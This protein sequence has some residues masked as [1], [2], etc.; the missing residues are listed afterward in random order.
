MLSTAALKLDDGRAD[1]IL[2]PPEQPDVVD[3]SR[4]AR[5]LLERLIDRQQKALREEIGGDRSLR[6]SMAVSRRR[7]LRAP[8][9]EARAQ[10]LHV[11]VGRGPRVD[12]VEQKLV[13]HSVVERRE[14]EITDPSKPVV[15][16]L[17]DPP[18]E[19]RIGLLPPPEEE[20]AVAALQDVA[21]DDLE[22]Q[23]RPP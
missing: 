10:P 20:N 18:L 22:L 19:C 5:R 7:L 6:D 23:R 11:A 4:V 13:R 2:G 3:V 21:E 16:V 8:R 15:I 14:I 12:R 9:A 17:A 1:V